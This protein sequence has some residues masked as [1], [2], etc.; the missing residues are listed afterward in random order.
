MHIV[1]IQPLN[2]ITRTLTHAFA[3]AHTAASV[4]GGRMCWN[5]ATAVFDMQIVTCRRLLCFCSFR[6]GV[7]SVPACDGVNFRRNSLYDSSWINWHKMSM[8]PKS[9]QHKERQTS[10]SLSHIRWANNANI[11][12]DRERNKN[13]HA[14]TH[15]HAKANHIK[16]AREKA[17]KQERTAPKE[18][19]KRFGNFGVYIFLVLLFFFFSYFGLLLVFGRYTSYFAIGCTIKHEIVIFMVHWI[20]HT[21]TRTHTRSLAH[22]LCFVYFCF[23]FMVCHENL[24]VVSFLSSY[25]NEFE[26]LQYWPP[27]RA[28]I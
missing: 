24:A 19:Q 15:T 23:N 7:G 18:Q 3:Y 6:F 21:H 28:K 16:S 5:S 20:T 4:K 8:P 17:W 12:W 27:R 26:Y 1:H 2:D 22:C 14:H 11:V 13:T 25:E 9:V 10:E